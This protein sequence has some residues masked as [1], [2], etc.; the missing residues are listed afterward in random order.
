MEKARVLNQLDRREGCKYNQIANALSHYATGK[1]DLEKELEELNLG[2]GCI[3]V[4]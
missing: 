3:W 2:G 1:F 4:F